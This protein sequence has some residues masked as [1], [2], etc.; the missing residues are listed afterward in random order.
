M[1]KFTINRNIN[2]YLKL[3]RMI[4]TISVESRNIN[5]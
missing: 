1:I 3:A 5:Y 4:R 2:Y